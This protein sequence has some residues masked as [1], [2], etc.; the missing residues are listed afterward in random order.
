MIAV[1]AKVADHV[2]A[3]QPMQAIEDTAAIWLDHEPAGQLW[4]TSLDVAPSED[5]YCPGAQ[6]THALALVD[7]QVVDHVPATHLAQ[8]WMLVAATAVE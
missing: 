7:D 4:Q 2:P 8:A 5:E 1:A 6:F 3:L